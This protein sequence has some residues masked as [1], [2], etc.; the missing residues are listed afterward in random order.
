MNFSCCLLAYA[1]GGEITSL[2][3]TSVPAPHRG[4]R[5]VLLRL[6]RYTSCYEE[7][8]TGKGS[9]EDRK[10]DGFGGFQVPCL[11]LIIR[12]LESSKSPVRVG[13]SMRIRAESPPGPQGHLVLDYLARQVRKIV[14]ESDQDDNHSAGRPPGQPGEKQVCRNPGHQ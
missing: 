13:R 3:G 2:I 1:L 6:R 12:S 9:R 14:P 10:A 7:P 8:S 4:P 11:Q 5:A